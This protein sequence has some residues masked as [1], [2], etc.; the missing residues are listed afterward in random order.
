MLS[1]K[2]DF[3]KEWFYICSQIDN[4]IWIFSYTGSLYGFM[5]SVCNYYL[6]GTLRQD[7][8]FMEGEEFS[9]N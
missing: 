7:N 5:E 3:T 9:L 2:A 8:G 1:A 6:H 4:I